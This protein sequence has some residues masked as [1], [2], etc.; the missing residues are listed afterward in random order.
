MKKKPS[1]QANDAILFYIGLLVILIFFV[2]KYGMLVVYVLSFPVT[3]CIIYSLFCI[4]KNKD[5]KSH[6]SLM[7]LVFNN[8]ILFALSLIVAITI[9]YLIVI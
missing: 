8:I 6:T 9:A 2:V 4:A 3:I 7:G 5:S 1:N